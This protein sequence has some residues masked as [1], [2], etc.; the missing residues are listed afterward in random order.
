MSLHA[1]CQDDASPSWCRAAVFH[2]AGRPLTIERHPR[3]EPPPG[4]VRLRVRMATLC[5]SD[6]KTYLGQRIEPTPTVLGHEFVGVLETLG[7]GTSP[8]DPQGRLLAPGDRVVVATVASCG[9]CFQCVRGLP[10]KC[11]ST[12]KCKYGHEPIDGPHGLW[13]GGLADVVLVAPGSGLVKVPDTLPDPIASTASC[14]GATVAGT[15]RVS[16]GVKGK[17]VAVFGAGMLGLTACAWARW[18]GALDIV[19]LDP[20][21]ERLETAA[22]F[23]ATATLR[24]DDPESPARLV[25]LTGG[26]GVDLALELSGHPQAVARAIASVRT[27]GQVVLI[28]SV[29]PGPTVALDPETV[30][31]RC[32]TIRGLHNS[33]PRDLLR[34]TRFLKAATMFPWAELVPRVYPLEE[35][36]EAFEHARDHRPPRV[37][38]ALTGSVAQA[39]PAR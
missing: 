14:A 27:G 35:V 29:A 8:R 2:E 28:G 19:A 16:G 21:S 26:R 1:G 36:E 34:A 22:R 13:T 30:V 4:R 7:P 20:L 38:V 3:P 25:H 33:T 31:R 18:A 24:A 15:L 10:Q 39:N 11:E 23:G 37:A 12:G 9:L 5:G 32:L 6:L 17:R